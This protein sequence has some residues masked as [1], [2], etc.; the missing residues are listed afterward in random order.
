MKPK[1]LV[2]GKNMPLVKDFVKHTHSYFTCLGCTD[3]YVDVY[4][5]FKVFNPDLYVC[6]IESGNDDNLM[7]LKKIKCDDDYKNTPVVIVGTDDACREC[8]ELKIDYS[9][10]NIRRPISA[11]NIA[12]RIIK[13]LETLEEEKQV[14][15]NNVE[16]VGEELEVPEKKHLLVVDDDRNVLKLLKASLSEDYEVTTMINGALVEKF[17]DTKKVDL[18]ILDYEMPIETGAEVFRKLKMNDK[19]KNVPVCFLTGVAER[20]KIEE[21]MLLKPHGYL[22]KPINMEMLTST[23]INLTS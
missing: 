6:F 23:I 13:L 11:D 1:I 12:L 19:Y 21:I 15:Q 4:E 8:E 10:L 9:K 18:I 17:L 20:S 16:I 7:Q 5:H 2:S 3:C 14:T 22:L